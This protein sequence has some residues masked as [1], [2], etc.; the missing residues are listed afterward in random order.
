MKKEVFSGIKLC[1]GLFLMMY[2]SSCVPANKLSY[3]NDIDELGKPLV[4]PK[5]QKTILP[6]DRLY[7]R[8]LSID[9]QTRQIFDMPEEIRYSGTGNSVLGLSG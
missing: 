5:V 3:F 6:F 7:I 9:P 8:I 2:I 1:L 4:N